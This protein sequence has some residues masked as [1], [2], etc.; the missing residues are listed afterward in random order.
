MNEYL[1]FGANFTNLGFASKY[2]SEKDA[3]P[4]ALQAGVTGFI[5]I[6]DRWMVHLSVDAYRRADTKAQVLI[7]GLIIHFANLASDNVPWRCASTS[8]PDATA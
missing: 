4:L 3:A 7:G 8:F 5:P 2:E 6:L 1:S